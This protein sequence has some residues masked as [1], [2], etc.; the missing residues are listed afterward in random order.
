MGAISGFCGG[1]IK[2]YAKH[3]SFGVEKV[4]RLKASNH[5]SKKGALGIKY[6]FNRVKSHNRR[7]VHSIELYRPHKGGNP[8]NKWH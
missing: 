2:G 8:H 4:G 3:K 7:V 5:R 1:G 6:H